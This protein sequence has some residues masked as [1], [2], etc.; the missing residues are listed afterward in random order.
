MRVSVIV[1]RRR[2]IVR[3]ANRIFVRVIHLH[4]PWYQKFIE[5]SS[6]F[7][8]TYRIVVFAASSRTSFTR[9]LGG[10][11]DAPYILHVSPNAWLPLAAASISRLLTWTVGL[12]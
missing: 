10:T 8:C 6:W 11:P 4:S 3:A 7:T 2:V 9:S 12:P 5:Y 1:F